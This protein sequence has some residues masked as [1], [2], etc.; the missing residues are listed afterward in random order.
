M[1]SSNICRFRAVTSVVV[2]GAIVATMAVA[3]P[4]FG[5]ATAKSGAKCTK[6][7]AKSG[8]LV[9]TK[10]GSKLVWTR[11]TR[12]GAPTTTGAADTAAAGSTATTG[13]VA[14]LTSVQRLVRA[15][16]I[17][18]ILRYVCLD[19]VKVTPGCNLQVLA[20]EAFVSA[21]RSGSKKPS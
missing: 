12:T 2:A 3:G 9:C 17:E 16:V 15:T 14:T 19:C 5:A 13:A 18:V 20:S 6:A 7:G 8:T 21:S 4:A 10:Q 11:V 1:I